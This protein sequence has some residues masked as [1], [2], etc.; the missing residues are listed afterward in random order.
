[1]NSK[2][3]SRKSKHENESLDKLLD[4]FK[5]TDW[6]MLLIGDGSGSFWEQPI[7]WGCISIDKETLLR[8]RW[9]GSMNSGTV[10]VAE[11]MAYLQPLLWFV[12]NVIEKRKKDGKAV[13]HHV[14]VITDSQYVRNSDNRREMLAS[15]L[16]PIWRLFSQFITHGVMLHWHWAKRETVALNKLADRLS[17]A[18]RKA[19]DYKA[20]F[21]ESDERFGGSALDTLNPVE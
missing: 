12:S 5:I 14:H 11:A 19:T 17:K 9:C 10:N 2:P 4:R 6:S 16:G 20:M 21:Q 8:K 1:M 15:G 7:G 13:V 3:S 18:S